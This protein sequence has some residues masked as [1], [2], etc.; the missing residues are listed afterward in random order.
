MLTK[1]E[2]L[3]RL[4]SLVACVALYRH[5]GIVSLGMCSH[6]LANLPIAGELILNVLSLQPL[7]EL[8]VVCKDIPRDLSLAVDR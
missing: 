3:W 8:R 6:D 2:P 5:W 4:F 7:V 1:Q